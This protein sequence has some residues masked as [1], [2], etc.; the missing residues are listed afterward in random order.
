MNPKKLAELFARIQSAT[1]LPTAKIEQAIRAGGLNLATATPDDV[2]RA[3]TRMATGEPMS[4]PGPA[5]PFVPPEPAPVAPPATRSPMSLEDRVVNDPN[6]RK[7]IEESGQAYPAGDAEAIMEAMR[8]GPV[9][10]RGRPKKAATED[11]IRELAKPPEPAPAPERIA[12]EFDEQIDPRSRDSAPELLR[13]PDEGVMDG[14]VPARQMELAAEQAGAAR[15]F[16]PQ[17]GLTT[18]DG[19]PAFDVLMRRN[20]E[21]SPPTRYDAF[22]F[23]EVPPRPASSS[24]PTRKPP[25]QAK[26]RAGMSARDFATAAGAGALA[27]GAL[28]LATRPA[29]RSATPADLA[30]ESRPAPKVEATP[31][32]PQPTVAQAPRDYSMEAR[33]LINRLNDMRRAAGGEVPE[34]KAMMAEINRLLELANQTRS[35]TYVAAPQDNASRLYQQA[36]ALIDQV[37]ALYRQ[38]QSPNSPEVQRLMAEVRRLQQQGDSL[39]NNPRSPAQPRRPR[40]REMFP[41]QRGGAQLIPNTRGLRP[42]SG[43][44]TT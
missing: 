38:G 33:A 44:N 5:K 20:M 7:A 23:D 3:A 25:P 12:A 17:A 4:L 39:R 15:L 2:F 22:T 9:Q 30:E 14:A 10:R 21:A 34:A 27:A 36:Q 1:G 18:V 11:S 41:V 24:P 19:E 16:S 6:L 32:V 13:Q 42:R 8:R 26:P 28:D 31:E 43:P 35:A 37:N 40:H 29:T